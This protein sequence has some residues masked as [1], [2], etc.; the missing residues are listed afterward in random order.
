M[1]K[2]TEAVSSFMKKAGHHDTTVHERVAPAVTH[3][4]VKPTQHENI[5]T[6]VDREIHQDH[7]HTSVQPVHDRQILP[8]QHHNKVAPVEH[9]EFNQNDHSGVKA[10]LADTAAQFSDKHTVAPTV[11]SRSAAPVVTGEH[12]HHHVHET[13]QP[14]VHKETVQPHVVHTTVPVH[15]VHNRSAQHHQTSTLPAVS[16]GDFNKAGGVLNG[17]EER[18]DGFEGEPRNIGG[19]TLGLGA[20]GAAG[21]AGASGTH[22]HRERRGSS[23]SFSSSDEEKRAKRGLG[24][25]HATAGTTGALGAGAAGTG[26]TGSHHNTTAGP[27]DSNAAN[28]FDP[29]VDSDRDGSNKLGNTHHSA[30]P[31]TT[32]TTGTGTGSTAHK[33]GLLAK[34]DPRVDSNGDGQKGFMK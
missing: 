13:I 3:E 22:R 7:H 4:T 16:L 8:E 12:I 25:K 27:H 10:K 6:A 2:A 23:S 20:A 29:R 30:A 24:K 14:V 19:S 21:A 17:R 5:T 33:S 32:S 11:E 9:R 31:G 34:L 1:Q 15:E 26:L 18:F 28:K